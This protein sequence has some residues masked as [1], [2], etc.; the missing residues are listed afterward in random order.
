[1]T[2]NG[3]KFIKNVAEDKALQEKLKNVDLD[4]VFQVAKEMGINLKREDLFIK[5][6]ELTDDELNAVSGGVLRFFVDCE[7][8]DVLL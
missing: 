6:G 7:T 5:K 2:G 8:Q 4:Y 3:K 1:M